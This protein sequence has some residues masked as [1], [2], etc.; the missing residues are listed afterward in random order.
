VD[1]V[2]ARSFRAH[3]LAERGLKDLARSRIDTTRDVVFQ[4]LGARFFE[5]REDVTRIANLFREDAFHAPDGHFARL[6]LH[7]E[8]QLSERLAALEPRA[9]ESRLEEA[10]RNALLR[11]FPR[12][13]GA[14]LVRFE[15][16][17]REGLEPVA[18]VHLSCRGS[19]GSP[20][21]ALNWEHAR[22]FEAT[23]N[24]EVD[25]VFGLTRA[26]SRELE[27]ARAQDR[28]SVLDPAAERL[29]E[30]WA[31]ASARLFAVYTDRLA[32]KAT[33]KE[34]AEAA[35]QARAARTAWSRLA[36]PAI[37][38][39][40]VERRQV[41]DVIRLRIAGGSRY[42]RGPL[43]A[44]RR[45]LLETAASRAADLPEGTERRLAVVTWPAGPDL[46]ATVYFNQ[47]SRPERSPGSL[48]PERLR[49]ALEARLPDEIRRLA[50]SLDAAAHARADELGRVEA[51]LPE[52]APV[53]E[54]AA[55]VPE[56][57]EEPARTGVAAAVVVAFDREH[58]REARAVA[59]S[60]LSD[61]QE[62]G[63]QIQP[64]ERDWSC[65]RVFAVRLRVPTG[66]EQLERMGLSA[67]EIAQV[68]QRAVDRA[69]P[70]LEREGIRDN[71]LY[72][73]HGRA[74]DVRIVVPE[75]LGWTPAQLRSPQFQQRFLMGFHH[76]IS[77]IAP[78]RMGPVREPL[79]PGLVRGVATI[80]RAPQIMRRAE[81]D[82]E[83][84]ARDV[85]RAVF[86]KLTEA[87]PKPFRLMRDLSRVV[88]RFVPRG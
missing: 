80:R 7:V 36:G 3:D 34:L 86:S 2:S 73:P 28:V 61:R 64:A 46:H 57:R 85:A 74:L 84:A 11:E 15:P 79:L 70:F 77:Q 32:G 6:V 26:Q 51:R 60:G 66:A 78:T 40:D 8:P 30:E 37:D 24:H 44:L 54:S 63:G 14:Y 5:A 10:T 88:S 17:P 20:S 58:E 59:P 81:Q 72:S 21:P 53:R 33:Q 45:T 41:F 42:L 13:Q 31:R 23:W 1:R 83:R 65:E 50:P 29:R 52:R 71:F 9:V 19:D 62:A 47:R 82:P 68:L 48:E 25:R 67:Q 12:A 39:R 22:R 18:H 49:T 38:L 87:L 4:A 69:Y 56:R 75:K 43:E 16:S 76:A 55:P 35:Q 27:H